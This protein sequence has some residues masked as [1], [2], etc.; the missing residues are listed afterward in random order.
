MIVDPGME[1]DLIIERIRAQSLMPAAVLVTHAHGDHIAGIPSMKAE[2]PK[3]PVYIGRDEAPK[4]GD[5]WANLSAPFGLPITVA[6]ADVLLDDGQVFEVAGIRLETAAVP[7]HSSGHVVFIWHGPERKVVF[8]G[9][10]LFHG[11]IGRTDFPGG[12]FA[13][14][15][16]GIREKLYTLPDDTLILSGHGPETT[17]GR[18][19]RSNPFVRPK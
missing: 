12:S 16:A 7:G 11:S 4:L 1:P 6:P 17:V 3:C 15:E 8:G 19:K 10:V 5:P 13:Q 14:L 9:D 18:E 2:W